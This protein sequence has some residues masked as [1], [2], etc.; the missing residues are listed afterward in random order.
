MYALEVELF[1]DKIRKYYREAGNLDSK[2]RKSNDCD[3]GFRC[4]V[5]LSLEMYKNGGNGQG[6][7]G[8][9]SSTLPLLRE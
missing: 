1:F 3:Y 7:V 9:R 2:M 6:I 5:N 4:Y 8:Y